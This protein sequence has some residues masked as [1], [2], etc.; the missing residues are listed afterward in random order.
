MGRLNDTNG[1]LVDRGTYHAFHQLGPFHPDR[2]LIHRGHATSPDL[3]GFTRWPGIPLMSDRLPGCTPH[4]RDP[5]VGRDAERPGEYRMLVGAQRKD[6]TG[7]A[8]LLRS[9]DLL[10][11]EPEGELIDSARCHV[12][13]ILE[14]GG[15]APMWCVKRR[16][17]AGVLV[18]GRR[19]RRFGSWRA[20]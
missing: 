20:G 15:G 14:L 4:T 7:T 8:V 11:W 10:R 19:G 5:Q 1:L 12:G 3:R 18:G 6:L 17:G 16:R 9:T 2:T 13:L